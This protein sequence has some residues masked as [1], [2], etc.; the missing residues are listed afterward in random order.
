MHNSL[1]PL[2]K[3]QVPP[4]QILH[5]MRCFSLCLD[6]SVSEVMVFNSLEKLDVDKSKAANGV[7]PCLLKECQKA[8]S[9]PLC[10]LLCLSLQNEELL[11]DWKT[12]YITSIQKK[13]RRDSAENYCPIKITSAVVK[14]LERF[15]IKALI[16]HLEVNNILST[17]QHGFRSGRSVNTNLIQT[18]ELVTTLLDKGCPVDMILLDLF[19]AFNKVCHDFLII[20]LKAAGVVQWIMGFL[21]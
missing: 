10:M 2:P 13:G 14:V 15:V 5:Y 4:H 1:L 11:H 7:H 18:Y 9:Y 21:S 12:S 8:L 16:E 19:K 17:S 6:L 20:K 3:T